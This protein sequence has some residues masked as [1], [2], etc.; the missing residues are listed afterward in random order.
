[1]R[2]DGEASVEPLPEV[3]VEWVRVRGAGGRARRRRLGGARG[4]EERRGRARVVAAAGLVSEH[5]VRHAHAARRVLARRQRRRARARHRRHRAVAAA[6]A[7]RVLLR[8]QPQRRDR[9]RHRRT[10]LRAVHAVWIRRCRVRTGRHSATDAGGTADA[11][12][13]ASAHSTHRR[14]CVEAVHG[15][16]VMAS[17]HDRSQWIDGPWKALSSERTG[18]L[19]SPIVV[20]VGGI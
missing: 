15:A 20:R 1:M 13:A 3:A 12:H 17:G 14:R 2:C 11:A 7:R 6:E 19:R 5:A 18:H 4:G 10:R 16:L 8:L 9:R